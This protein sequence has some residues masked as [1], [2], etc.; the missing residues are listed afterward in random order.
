[1]FFKDNLSKVNK[2]TGFEPTETILDV[3]IPSM[4]IPEGYYKPGSVVKIVPQ[5]LTVNPD[6]STHEYIPD[7][8]KVF[9]SVIVNKISGTA[10]QADVKS[11]KTFAS[12]NG[13]SL[14]GTMSVFNNIEQSLTPNNS[15]Y[16]LRE[17]YYGDNC[18]V[19][20]DH[21]DLEI[22]PSNKNIVHQ[23]S[24]FIR[25]LTVMG[26][27]GN[28]TPDRVLSGYSFCS[29]NTPEC[30]GGVAVDGTMPNNGD[31]EVV[32]DTNN[33]DYTVPEGYHNGAGVVRIVTEKRTATLATA[34]FTIIPSS[35]KVLSSVT[36]PAVSGTAT[37]GHVLNGYSFNSGVGI[38]LKGT[39]A[40][41]ASATKVADGITTDSSNMYVAIPSNGYYTTSSKLS[42]SLTSVKDVIGCAEIY[43]LGT[44]TSFNVSS[45]EGYQNFTANNFLVVPSTIK[46]SGNSN[47]GNGNSEGYVNLGGSVGASGSNST[48]LKKSYNSSTG[49]LTISNTSVSASYSN[50][51]DGGKLNTG[52][53]CSGSFGSIKVYLVIGTIK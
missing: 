41:Y 29:A 9:G 19:V 24:K 21:E 30:A 14:A 6:V 45:Y 36:I 33:T 37:P 47:A 1:M 53:N 34:A 28:A 15:I 42:A 7:D 17:G 44:G 25:K 38:G 12:E 11:G 32:L 27:P 2:N 10:T 52:G 40:S 35:G 50:S 39:M 51:T 20:V 18:S 16:N 26:I 22:Y 13:V 48:T 43:Y 46:I 4:A 3:N 5:D 49:K 8:G 23:E 31:I